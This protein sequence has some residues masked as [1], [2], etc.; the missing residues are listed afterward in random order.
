MLYLIICATQNKR[1]TSSII[2]REC[3][4][5]LTNLDPSDKNVVILAIKKFLE[6]HKFHFTSIDVKSQLQKS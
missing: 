6:T 4:I 2:K 3:L 5:K 1:M